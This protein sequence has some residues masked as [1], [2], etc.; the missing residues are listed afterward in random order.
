MGGYA[1]V[2]ARHL[3]RYAPLV[4]RTWFG[5]KECA[6]FRWAEKNYKKK[7]T[8]SPVRMFH[9]KGSERSP[10]YAPKKKK[11]KKLTRKGN[12]RVFDCSLVHLCTVQRAFQCKRASRRN[13]LARLRLIRSSLCARFFYPNWSPR[14]KT[15]FRL[16]STT[17]MSLLG[18]TFLISVIFISRGIP[19]SCM[20]MFLSACS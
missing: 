8:S 7:G 16:N 12:M 5:F 18:E 10:R 13:P 1:V 11:K 14:E 4:T 3:C 15:S 19:P 17:Y 9:F 2:H 6:K 20:R